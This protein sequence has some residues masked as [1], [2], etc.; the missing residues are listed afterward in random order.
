M[1]GGGMMGGGGVSKGVGGEA[2]GRWD[3]R[4]RGG[5]KS[6]ERLHSHTQT[7]DIQQLL[8]L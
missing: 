2:G 3:G 8:M 1:G 4:T 5:V 6:A 7:Q